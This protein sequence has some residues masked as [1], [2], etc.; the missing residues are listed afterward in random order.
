[1]KYTNTINVVTTENGLRE[2]IG[3]PIFE[4]AEKISRLSNDRLYHVVITV[5]TGW[6]ASDSTRD[7]I[8]RL[9]SN[10]TVTKGI[11]AAA[12]Q[13]IASVL[14]QSHAEFYRTGDNP[15]DVEQYIKLDPAVNG[16]H[17]YIYS[18]SER[19]QQEMSMYD[20]LCKRMDAATNSWAKS[21]EALKS[22]ISNLEQIR[23]RM[24]NTPYNQPMYNRPNDY[25]NQQCGQ[26]NMYNNQYRNGNP[27]QNGPARP[28]TPNNGPDFPQ[29]SGG[30]FSDAF[31]DAFGNWGKK[32]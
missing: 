25:Y 2:L 9:T 20:R 10:T 7:V 17:R 8:D 23:Q 18:D 6:Y 21:M 19:N 32:N 30:I 11:S 5:D 4:M 16:D 24:H 3:N 15:K 14:S 13:F 22:N 1:M 28:F 29:Q 26:P 27:F 31:A 12:Q